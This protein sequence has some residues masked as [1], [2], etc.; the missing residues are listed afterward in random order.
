[1]VKAKTRLSGGLWNCY[2]EVTN[3]NRDIIR[4]DLDLQDMWGYLYLA[5]RG[6]EVLLRRESGCVP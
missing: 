4:P 3:E 1:M 5:G 6:A 2:S